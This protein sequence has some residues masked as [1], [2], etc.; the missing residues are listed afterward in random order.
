MTYAI[1]AFQRLSAQRLHKREGVS[2]RSD[3]LI[4]RI[5]E[6]RPGRPG[7]RDLPW[8][9]AEQALKP[10][11]AIDDASAHIPLID[12]AIGGALGDRE[13]LIGAP[14]GFL[15]LFT[16]CDVGVDQDSAGD[17]PILGL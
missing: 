15:Q 11:A 17:R 1:F 3:L 7:W 16:L 5:H 13:S 4:A 2:V 6:L 12:E 14:E 10:R 8:P 9:I